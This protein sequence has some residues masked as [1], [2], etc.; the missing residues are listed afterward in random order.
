MLVSFFANAPDHDIAFGRLR[1]IFF[2]HGCFSQFN[3]VGIIGSAGGPVAGDQ[4]QQCF[5]NGP[6]S[7]KRRTAGAIGITHDIAQYLLQFFGIGTHLLNGFLGFPQFGGAD[8][9]HCLGDLLGA[10]DGFDPVTNFLELSCHF[11]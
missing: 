3:E 6:G 8:H 7:G 5:F 2:L 11:R 1:R 9:F 10:L 4:D